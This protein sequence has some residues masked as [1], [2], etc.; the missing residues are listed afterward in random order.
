[1]AKKHEFRMDPDSSGGFGRLL[2]TKKQR[3]GLLKWALYSVLCL[4]AL[5]AQD[6]VLYRLD[7][8]GATTDLVP[9]LILMIAVMEG[10]ENGSLFSFLAGLVYYCS[11]SAP[12]AYVIP[13]LTAAAVLLAIFRQSYLQEGFLA[14]AMCAAMGMIFYELCIFGISLLLAQTL[15]SRV[16]VLA[17]TAVLSLVLVPAAYPVLRAIGNIGGETWKD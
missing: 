17:M 4:L 10:V 6:V 14:V 1:M 3:I 16:G 8:L 7:I 5:I 2:L 11:G 13:V 15:L 12:G 9:C